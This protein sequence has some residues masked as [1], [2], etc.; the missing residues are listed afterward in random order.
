MKTS[1]Y[2]LLTLLFLGLCHTSPALAEGG[3]GPFGIRGGFAA[4]AKDS[5][6]TQ[7]EAFG[8]YELP[9]SLRSKGGWGISTYLAL[10]AGVLKS[11]GEYGLIGSLGPSFSLGNPQVFP[12]ELDLGISVALLSRERFGTRDY[13][14]I[15][16]FISHGGLIYHINRHLGLSYRY[17]HMSNAGFNGSPNPGLNMHLFGIN[18]YPDR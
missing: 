1:G 7:Y 14:G 10:T 17:Q 6:T 2:L 9:W 8:E 3:W 4:D 12:L 5:N 18:W 15:E 13:N 11:Q 16:Q